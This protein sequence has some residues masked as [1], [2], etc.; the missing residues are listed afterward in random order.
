MA[1]LGRQHRP[2]AAIAE[3]TAS[4]ETLGCLIPLPPAYKS[5]KFIASY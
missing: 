1:I 3:L 4:M 2:A 5:S